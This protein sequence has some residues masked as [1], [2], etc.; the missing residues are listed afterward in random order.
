MIPSTAPILGLRMQSDRT[1]PPLEFTEGCDH[2]ERVHVMISQDTTYGC[3]DY[4][5]RV[6][7]P[8]SG[9]ESSACSA[10]EEDDG[11]SVD[12]SLDS[13]DAVCRERMATWKLRVVDHFHVPRETVAVSFSYLDRFVD[14]CQCDRSAFKLAAMT[15]LYMAAKIFGSSH[16]IT[17][18]SLADLSRGEFEMSHISEME[19]IILQT[20]EW[21]LNP[22]TAQCFINSFYNYLPVQQGPVSIAIYQRAIF[23]V[24]LALYDYSFVTKKR[25]LVA[26]AALI[27]AM[28]GLNESTFPQQQQESFVDIICTTFGLK[29]SHEE[30]ESVRN[31]LWYVYSMSAQYKEDDAVSPDTVKRDPQRKHND[32]DAMQVEPS[33]PSSSPV[34]VAGPVSSH[35]HRS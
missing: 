35:H 26:L 18:R 20:L 22:P 28:E 23:F 7:V 17:I 3:G 27:N 32:E 2:V 31:R 29:F 25:A 12:P 8:S 6:S 34:S 4:L 15:T 11:I 9:K 10:M 1:G 16:K 13:I 33:S 30:I 14:R 19:T 21:R 24:E 5:S